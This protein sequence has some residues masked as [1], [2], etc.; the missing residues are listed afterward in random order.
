M[1]SNDN[2]V[3]ADLDAPS[4]KSQS[5]YTHPYGAVSFTDE[6]AIATLS[7]PS[8]S[9]VLTKRRQKS[10]SGFRIGERHA[11][12]GQS[13]VGVSGRANILP[14]TAASKARALSRQFFSRSTLYGKSSM[15]SKVDQDL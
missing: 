5:L 2:V 9:L 6:A 15:Y 8:F 13:Q 7:L 4:A 1:G 11:N 3:E 10:D 14:E 12:L